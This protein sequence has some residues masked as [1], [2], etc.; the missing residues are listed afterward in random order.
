MKAPCFSCRRWGVPPWHAVPCCPES[1]WEVAADPDVAQW[2]RERAIKVAWLT[3]A[4]R[5]VPG[6]TVERA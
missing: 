1:T 6:L 3:N 2:L 4:R 5:H